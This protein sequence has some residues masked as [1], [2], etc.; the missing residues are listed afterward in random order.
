MEYYSVLKINEL[1]RRKFVYILL[2]E[3]SQSEKAT[4]HITPTTWHSGN[5]KGK[6]RETV[7][8][9][10]AARGGGVGCCRDKQAKHRGRLGQWKYFVW[11]YNDDYMSLYIWQNPQNVQHQEW[12]LI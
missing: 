7:K 2:S 5:G 8:R 1:S 9:P 3:G 10:M 12:T 11:Y 4:Y 6:T